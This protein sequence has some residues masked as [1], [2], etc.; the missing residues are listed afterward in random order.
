MNSNCQFRPHMSLYIPS[1]TATTT[2]EQFVQVFKALNIGVVSRVDFVKR[3][4]KNSQWMAFVHFDFWYINNT[5]YHLQERI[6]DQGQARIVYNEPYYWIVMENK[7]PRT[8]MEVLLEKQVST[9]QQKISYLETVIETQSKKLHENDIRTKTYP[10]S[11]CYTSIPNEEEECKA[12]EPQEDNEVNVDNT[13]T[14]SSAGSVIYSG[15]AYE[16]GYDAA[17]LA[18]TGALQSPDS[19]KLRQ[20]QEK[21]KYGSSTTIEEQVKSSHS[22]GWWPFS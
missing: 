5:S 14:L 19:D 12:C 22:S 1:V 6:S 13:L 10:C 18:M 9:L 4:S 8:Q 15:E 17:A 2:Q 11:K 20:Q 7:N 16:Y 21:I 3:E